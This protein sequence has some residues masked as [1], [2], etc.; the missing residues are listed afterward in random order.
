MEIANESA[1]IRIPLQVGSEVR[2]KNS[3]QIT[4]GNPQF[5]L[6]GDLNAMGAVLIYQFDPIAGEH[7]LQLLNPVAFQRRF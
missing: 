5:E 2:I 4:W 3:G 1:R 7:I 6:A